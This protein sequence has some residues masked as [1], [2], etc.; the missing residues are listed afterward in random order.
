MNQVNFI[1]PAKSHAVV[2]FTFEDF[3]LDTLS[4]NFPG[5]HLDGNV[6]SYLLAAL[7]DDEP[8]FTID[9]G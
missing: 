1:A 4:G 8:H 7:F 9:I 6:A 3:R 5:G 2:L